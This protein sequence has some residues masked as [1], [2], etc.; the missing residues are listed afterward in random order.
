LGFA[1]FRPQSLAG[2]QARKA[3]TKVKLVRL[4]AVS[5]PLG[6][7]LKQ[8]Y[9]QTGVRVVDRRS[10]SNVQPQLKLDL[11]DVSFWEAIDAIAQHT[12]SH[13][14]VYEKDNVVALRDGLEPGVPL[15]YS[16]RFR[17][18][19]KRIDASQNFETQ[20]RSCVIRLELAW[21][22]TVQPL[23]VDNRPGDIKIF[24]DKGGV[25]G[26][27][28]SSGRDPLVGRNAVEIPVRFP[29]PP[30]SMDRL[31]RVQGPLRVVGPEQLLTFS[32]DHLSPA[33]PP[34][35]QAEAGV[36]A[37]IH[38]FK[39]GDERWKIS[40]LLK[41][42]AGEPQFESFESWLSTTQ[43][44]LMRRDGK[45]ELAPVGYEMAE[46][47][48]HQVLLTYYFSKQKGGAPRRP[49]DWKLV[50]RTPGRIG[51]MAVPFAF[52]DLPLP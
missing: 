18:A 6:Q 8:L 20:T 27:S 3:P 41:H 47:G 26:S 21:E 39:E 19:V 32:F 43:A 34:P 51:T 40:L 22:P 42:P 14:S 45:Q 15:W 9:D 36:T 37:A 28:D 38:E 16:G 2:D 12:K 29:A 24:D 30:R 52:K 10:S 33:Q 7:A 4:H 1:G 13:V 5:M 31:H 44:V 50:C 11:E 48:E 25:I 17:V 46:Q 23:F 35:A 49:Q